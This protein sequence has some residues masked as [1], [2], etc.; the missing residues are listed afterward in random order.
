MIASF[1]RLT[2]G[3][4][5]AMLW[6][7]PLVVLACDDVSP[8]RQSMTIGGQQLIF[9]EVN[10]AQAFDQV[11]EL[12]VVVHGQNGSSLNAVKTGVKIAKGLGR[13][14]TALVLAPHFLETST[15]TNMSM[16]PLVWSGKNNW[17]RGDL[18][19]GPADS[20]VSSFT[21]MD[22]LLHHY[23]DRQK[24]PNLQSVLIL[25]HSAGGQY[26]QR[27]AIGTD[28]DI[29][30]PS[31]RFVF[32]VANPS[33]YMYLSLQRPL[34]GRLL[35]FDIPNESRCEWN[36]GHYGFGAPNEYMSR[37]SES[38]LIQRYLQRSVIYA[39]G[40]L[41]SDPFHPQLGRSPCAKL[42]GDHRLDRGLKYFSFLETFF[43]AHRHALVVVDGVG[44][45]ASRML[46]S[47]ALIR[48]LKEQ[49]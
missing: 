49:F 3:L 5:G 31:L 19:N 40:S 15:L 10:G 14:S 30:N 44:H 23:M 25:G 18:S 37:Y 6:F 45:E 28:I 12:I 11:R 2:R 39:L 26:V 48:R 9:Y 46:T 1:W 34:P 42:Q 7:F 8:C 47:E 21:V 16:N 20:R 36:N 27:Y 38:T 29:K 17:R 24:T 4:G 13:Y 43:P 41:D 22:L 33:T 35:G 32:S